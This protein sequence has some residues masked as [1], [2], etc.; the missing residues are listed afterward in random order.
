MYVPSSCADDASRLM[1]G[2]MGSGTLVGD[3]VILEG[4]RGDCPSLWTVVPVALTFRSENLPDL[5][6]TPRR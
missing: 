6:D 4:G 3:L 2:V 5:R 1:E